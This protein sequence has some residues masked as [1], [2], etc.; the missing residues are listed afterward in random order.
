MEYLAKRPAALRDSSSER[1]SGGEQ[2]SNSEG[3][4]EVD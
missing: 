1:N 2:D 4:D 3:I